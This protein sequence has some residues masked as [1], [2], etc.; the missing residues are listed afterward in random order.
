LAA[1]GWRLQAAFEQEFSYSGVPVFPGKPYSY[2]AFRRQGAFGERFVGALAAAGLAVE[3]FLPE[4]G[5]SQFE[6]TIQPAEGMAAADQAIIVREVARAVARRM[7]ERVS[8]TPMPTADGTGNGC[9]V[10]MSLM[11]VPGSPEP[12]A[13]DARFGMTAAMRA[14]AEGIRRHMPALCAVV[15]PSPVSYLRLTPNRWAPTFTDI[16]LQDRGTA[17]RVCPVP[18]GAEAAARAR[19][20]HVEFRIPDGAAS[21]WLALGAIVWAGVDGLR[22]GLDIPALPAQASNALGARDREL[23]GIHP[24]PASLGEAAEALAAD[25]AAGEWFGPGLLAAILGTR[26]AEAADFARRAP[27]ELCALFHEI[28]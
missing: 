19:G 26:R 10:H 22:R 13:P 3:S 18:A 7:G 28:Y 14:F 5:D 16:A 15:A 17:L 25:A 9:H 8:F 2:G 4:F 6:I 12:G 1:L 23:F 20:A 11:P 24:L 27:A 21:P